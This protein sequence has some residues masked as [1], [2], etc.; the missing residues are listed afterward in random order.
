IRAGR[1]SL[2]AQ[3]GAYRRRVPPAT[4]ALIAILAQLAAA[5]WAQTP[6]TP[7]APQAA[8]PAQPAP[9]PFDVS[10]YVDLYFQHDFGQPRGSAG[11]NGRW[12]DGTQGA[13]RISA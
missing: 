7:P 3:S 8:P 2:H 12:Y 6:P 11:V 5:A 10:G 13:Y 9:K 1:V 4:R